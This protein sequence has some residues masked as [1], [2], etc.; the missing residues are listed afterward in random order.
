MNLYNELKQQ[1][2]DGNMNNRLSA[3]AVFMHADN[4]A[5]YYKQDPAS[6]DEWSR[7]LW[8]APFY[9]PDI[10]RAATGLL[11]ETISQHNRRAANNCLSSIDAIRL[12]AASPQV[13]QAALEMQERIERAAMAF[14]GVFVGSD[15]K[16]HSWFASGISEVYYIELLLHIISGRDNLRALAA[17]LNLPQEHAAIM[18]NHRVLIMEK[19]RIFSPA[20]IAAI[21][22]VF[23]AVPSGN[24]ALISWPDQAYVVSKAIDRVNDG[25]TTA[26]GGGHITFLIEPSSIQDVIAVLLHEMAHNVSNNNLTASQSLF[27]K[28]YAVSYGSME[29]RKGYYA[30]SGER[31]NKYDIYG[32]FARSYGTRNVDE[33]LATMAEAWAQDSRKLISRAIA[34]ARAGRPWLLMKTLIVSTLFTHLD[35]NGRA[36]TYICK[37]E[38]RQGGK[39]IIR[40]EEAPVGFD[41]AAGIVDYIEGIAIPHGIGPDFGT[42]YGRLMVKNRSSGIGASGEPAILASEVFRGRTVPLEERHDLL[43][44]IMEQENE[45]SILRPLAIRERR[46]VSRRDFLRAA[47]AAAAGAVLH[48]PTG[49]QA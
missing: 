46:G 27:Y 14:A 18:E 6:M 20:Q 21:E 19:G 31:R 12:K 1:L 37:I 47:G 40:A 43:D 9:D 15:W 28:L 26:Q 34:L 48:Q 39:T 5:E 2:L 4:T 38:E 41:E 3:L 17:T 11:E 7:R 23:R 22:D 44:V 42:L 30:S 49:L 24:G 10:L 36:C 32:D 8:R 33:D 16:N 13:K 25:K 29:D 35:S 45:T